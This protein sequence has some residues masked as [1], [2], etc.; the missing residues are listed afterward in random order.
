MS[1]Y[2]VQNKIIYHRYRTIRKVIW[3]SKYITRESFRSDIMSL[4]SILNSY[5]DLVYGHHKCLYH[6]NNYY[7]EMCIDEMNERIRLE[8]CIHNMHKRFKLGV[9]I[10]EIL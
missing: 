8:D 7:T 3:N 5:T 1:Y 2:K 4:I 10:K 9:S 6:L